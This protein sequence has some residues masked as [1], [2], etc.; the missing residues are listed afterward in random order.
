MFH[1]FLTPSWLP[2]C[3]SLNPPQIYSLLPPFLCC[4]FNCYLIMVWIFQS[5]DH[6]FFDPI[7]LSKTAI[8]F[9]VTIPNADFC[10]YSLHYYFDLFLT[11]FALHLFTDANRYSAEYLRFIIIIA[12]LWLASELTSFIAFLLDW[13]DSLFVRFCNSICQDIGP[14]FKS[15]LLKQ[16]HLNQFAICLESFWFPLRKQNHLDHFL[17][18]AEL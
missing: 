18:F 7:V 14:F 8:I 15:M 2:S 6:L 10:Y 4:W 17:V 16:G 13:I 11:I 1:Y 9:I 5:W 3:C 12:L